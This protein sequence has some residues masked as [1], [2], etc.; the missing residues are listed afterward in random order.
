MAF[1][2]YGYLASS[3]IIFYLG[4]FYASV[5]RLLLYLELLQ[6]VD[7][8]PLFS[9]GQFLSIVSRR[10]VLFVD[11][12]PLYTIWRFSYYSIGVNLYYCMSVLLLLA[13]TAFLPVY[14][15]STYFCATV[16]SHCQFSDATSDISEF[17]RYFGVS[18]IY[19]CSL[20]C[21]KLVAS[22]LSSIYSTI[23]VILTTYL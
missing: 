10:S 5:D 14:G 17:L 12:S 4:N 9:I 2:Y 8:S 23:L 15:E 1:L 20:Y 6:W 19:R 3:S 11:R 7:R 18:T 13:P 22:I 16:L 21:N